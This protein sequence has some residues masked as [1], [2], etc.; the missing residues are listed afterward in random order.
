M[1]GALDAN[2]GLR[3]G[4]C[5]RHFVHRHEPPVPAGEPPLPT[6]AVHATQTTGGTSVTLPPLSCAPHA[7]RIASE[8]NGPTAC[9][10][11]RRLTDASAAQTSPQH[12]RPTLARGASNMSASFTNLARRFL[13]LNHNVE[14]NV[15]RWP[16]SSHAWSHQHGALPSARF[17]TPYLC[18]G[19]RCGSRLDSK[20]A[21]P[22][23]L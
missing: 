10:S 4:Q 21:S 9:M 13:P 7:L 2:G 19:E 23:L 22:P 5:A 11:V 16:R 8:C 18:C 20:S 12:H 1:E 17:G 15:P 6:L 14:R 3:P